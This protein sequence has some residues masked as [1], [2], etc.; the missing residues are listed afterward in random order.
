LRTTA[1][2][3]TKFLNLVKVTLARAGMV[4]LIFLAVMVGL[5]FTSFFIFFGVL[6]DLAMLPTPR[7]LGSNWIERVCLGEG[8]NPSQRGFT[9]AQLLADVNERDL[10]YPHL[11]C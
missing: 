6:D 10:D 4:F 9:D 1:A 8:Q 2:F 7:L 3:L 11:D 5:L